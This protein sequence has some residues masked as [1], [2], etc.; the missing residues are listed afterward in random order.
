MGRVIDSVAHSGPPRW[1]IGSPFHSGGLDG[2]SGM[3]RFAALQRAQSRFHG[4]SLQN[5]RL[6]FRQRRRFF[7]ILARFITHL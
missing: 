7:L 4:P 6:H 1:C 2:G 5:E 3:R